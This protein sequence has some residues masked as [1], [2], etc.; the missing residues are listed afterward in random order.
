VGSGHGNLTES[1][2]SMIRNNNEVVGSVQALIESA[3][4]TIKVSKRVCHE[5]VE[6]CCE[7]SATLSRLQESRAIRQNAIATAKQGSS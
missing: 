4:Q 6:L 3:Q 2:V 5:S 1:G 7:L